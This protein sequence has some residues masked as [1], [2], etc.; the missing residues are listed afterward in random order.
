M[1]C[2]ECGA[3]GYSRKT[4]TPEWRCSKRGHEWD[5]AP[6]GITTS[7]P[8]ESMPIIFSIFKYATTSGVF[9]VFAVGMMTF[10]FYGADRDEHIG[11]FGLRFL[12]GLPFAYYAGKGAA[13]LW[14]KFLAS[15]GD[16]VFGR[17]YPDQQ[18]Y[19]DQD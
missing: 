9:F 3:T 14:R 15:W 19:P 6:A 12:V 1:R 11:F 2:P 7:G 18:I 8:P 10:F 5:V 16:R 13:N 17:A 4:K